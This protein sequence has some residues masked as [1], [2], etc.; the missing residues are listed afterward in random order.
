M[1]RNRLAG[2]AAWKVRDEGGQ[3]K[4]AVRREVRSTGRSTEYG[5][6]KT[7][8]SEYLSIDLIMMCA[9]FRMIILLST[10]YLKCHFSCARASYRCASFFLATEFLPPSFHEVE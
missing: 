3:K 5:N 9:I 8:S 7:R 10:S 4:D 1:S 2:H 6:V